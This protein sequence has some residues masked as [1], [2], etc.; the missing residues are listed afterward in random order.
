MELFRLL[1][2]S[3]NI[4]ATLYLFLELLALTIKKNYPLDSS[5]LKVKAD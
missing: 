4:Q 5:K 3:L 1:V 2:F